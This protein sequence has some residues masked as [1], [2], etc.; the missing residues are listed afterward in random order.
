MKTLYVVGCSFSRDTLNYLE[1][2]PFEKFK[3][4]PF[5]WCNHLAKKLK[6]NLINESRGHG[7][8]DR[9]VRK[10]T[11]FVLNNNMKDVFIVIQFTW[12]ERL[13]YISNDG[14]Y[15]S[16]NWEKDIDAHKY[17]LN[18]YSNHYFNKKSFHNVI[19]LHHHLKSVGVKHLC[20]F[21]PGF[22][23]EVFNEKKYKSHIDNS[24][25]ILDISF[26]EL[27]T[28]YIAPGD[29]HPGKQ[30]HIDMAELIYNRLKDEETFKEH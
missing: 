19:N 1:N 26:R 27:Q 23:R 30:S 21:V 2:K 9:I 16:F 3:G 18:D 7:S 12:P 20:F 4:E 17:Y 14:N 15:E 24:N 28:D 11:D 25:F 5:L 29:L 8:N 13:E 10:V 22:M 6:C